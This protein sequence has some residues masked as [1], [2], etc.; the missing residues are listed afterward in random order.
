MGKHLFMRAVTAGLVVAS[1]GGAAVASPFVLLDRQDGNSNVGGEL[2][3][4][5]LDSDI[6]GTLVRFDVHGQYVSPSG[7]GGYLVVPF[8]YGDGGGADS[9]TVLGNV[10]AGGIYNIRTATDLSIVLHGGLTLPTAPND[11][12]TIVGL[13]S[14]FI[15]VHDFYQ[16]EPKGI[17]LRTGASPTFKTGKMFLRGD[18]GIDINVDNAGDETDDTLFHIGFGIGGWVS[19]EFAL[20]G[21][22][23]TTDSTADNSSSITNAAFS[24]RY[25]AGSIAPYFS[26]VLPL[27]SEIN[28]FV[29][30]GIV[31]GLD[32]DI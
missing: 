21:E 6:D 2:G 26:L 17:T 7:A 25:R 31:L 20:M 10:E 12:D 32:A 1:M 4:S 13:Q 22:F 15:R 18:L 19:P 23:V 11:N 9:V 24:G 3:Y 5:K 14:S 29:D 16:W 8:A 28:R 30:F 27:D